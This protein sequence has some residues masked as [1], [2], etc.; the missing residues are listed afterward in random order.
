MAQPGTLARFRWPARRKKRPSRA[1]AKQA[2]PPARVS[3]LTVP[4]V[5]IMISVAMAARPMRG[6]AVATTSVATRSCGAVWIEANGSTA[7]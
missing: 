6:S 7:R 4:K 3:A 5:E 1:I 2:R